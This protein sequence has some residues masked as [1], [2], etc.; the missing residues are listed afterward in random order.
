MPELSIAAPADEPLAPWLSPAR[1]AAGVGTRSFELSSRGDRVCGRLWLPDAAASR[2]P[3]W[4]AV[5]DLGRRASDPE[6][7]QTARDFARAGRA[8]AAIDLPLH[9][10]RANAKLSRR[11]IAAASSGE[12]AT[13]SERTLWLDLARQAV[14]DLARTIDA[15][16]AE[17][18]ALDRSRI[19]SLG[20]GL[21]SG[22]A[23]S[24]AALDTRVRAAVIVGAREVGLPELRPERCA[25]RF[26]PRPLLRVSAA[27]G[28]EHAA[29]RAA[30][31]EVARF[32]ADTEAG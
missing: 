23:L 12:A 18:P 24:H 10:E 1:S 21:A 32:L 25:A 19:A 3:W 30:Q 11:A 20:F 17:E 16:L 29:L 31:L 15:L 6:L 9:G 22:I 28:E 27:P 26:S 5:H 2:A 13:P 7:E 8:L 4:L 14:L